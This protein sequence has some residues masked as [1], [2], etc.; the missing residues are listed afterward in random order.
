LHL[1]LDNWCIRKQV[2]KKIGIAR[3]NSLDSDTIAERYTYHWSWSVINKKVKPQIIEESPMGRRWKVPD[4]AAKLMGGCLPH[5]F[6][7]H[8]QPP[9]CHVIC[10]GLQDLKMHSWCSGFK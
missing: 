5:A 4:I 1:S 6:C 2:L 3:I 10:F 7:P 9:I 8:I